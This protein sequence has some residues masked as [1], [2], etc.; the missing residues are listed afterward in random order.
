MAASDT[1]GAREF[2]AGEVLFKEGDAGDVFFVIREGTVRV[3][4]DIDGEMT[5]LAE[6]TAGDFVGEVAVVRASVQTATATAVTPTKCLV[7]S[8]PLLEQMVTEDA[9]IAV[10]VIRVLADRLAQTHDLLS[11]VGLRDTRTRV[12]MAIIRHAE[13]SGQPREDGIWISR[14]LGDIADEVAV[15]RQELGEISKEFLKLQLLRV[16][17][18]GILVPAVSRLYEFVKSG[19]V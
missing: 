15:S 3:W 14:R 13:G 2:V 17:R 5:T 7:V 12:A 4:K 9:E 18:D 11:M 19:D 6:L 8:G 16:K 1:L 10:R